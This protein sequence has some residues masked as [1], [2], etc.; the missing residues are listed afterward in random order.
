MMPDNNLISNQKQQVKKFKRKRKVHYLRG[1]YSFNALH[2]Y[3]L[4]DVNT[5]N[6]NI[7]RKLH[8]EILRRVHG[9]MMKYMIEESGTIS[10]PMGIGVLRVRKTKPRYNKKKDEIAYA[11]DHIN[12]KKYG[13]KIVYM[14]NHSDG[15]I[16]RFFW[17]RNCGY[18][19]RVHGLQV[20]KFRAT[21]KNKKYLS[22]TIM[23]HYPKID[24]FE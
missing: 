4:K 18:G 9:K 23:E 21:H 10:L 1:A 2:K 13:K 15:Y 12:S 16:M 8:K 6:F 24:Y 20:Y 14:N 17:K 22:K 3:Y 7:E 19:S 5:F 11:V